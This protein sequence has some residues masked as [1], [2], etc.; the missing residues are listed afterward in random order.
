MRNE[1]LIVGIMVLFALISIGNAGA[2]CGGEY[3]NRFP[4]T[5]PNDYANPV[6]AN[7]TYGVDF[8]DGSQLVWCNATANYL[9]Y[10]DSVNYACYLDDTKMPT[11][12]DEGNETDYGNAEKDLLLYMTLN[13]STDHSRYS[14]S[15]TEN[16]EPTRID[17][18]I[19]HAYSFDNSNDYIKADDSAF[20]RNA[21]KDKFTITAWVY[22]KSVDQDGIVSLQDR[23]A[24]EK[25]ILFVFAG[26]N[27]HCVVHT[28]S[29]FAD[30]YSPNFELNK[31]EMYTC[32][33]D[34]SNVKIYLNNT[35]MDT[36][37]LSGDIDYYS[38]DELWIG[39]R[40]RSPSEYYF[41]GYIDNVMIW[42]R[43]LSADE[44]EAIYNNTHPDG[45]SSL[46][47]SESNIGIF[48]DSPINS[49][50][51]KDPV[52]VTWSNVTD[53]DSV[54]Y[55]FNGGTNTTVTGYFDIYPDIGSNHLEMYMN[56]SGGTIYGDDV[57][58]T[59]TPT[60]TVSIT[61]P[62]N[63]TIVTPPG[64]DINW[65]Y[66]SA[67]ACSYSSYAVDGGSNIS[68]GC[69]NFTLD[70]TSLSTSLHNITVYA[71]N[72]F[73]YS[74]SDTIWI[75]V[76]NP[77]V[78]C[79][80]S[81]AIEAV[82][83]GFF[84][85]SNLINMAA[86]AEYSIDIVAD[87]YS[88]NYN[89]S[90]DNVSNFSICI[91]GNNHVVDMLMTYHAGGYDTRTYYFYHANLNTTLQNIS[92]YLIPSGESEKVEVNVRDS[93]DQDV[94]NA[95]VNIQRYYIDE[96]I[97]RTVAIGKTDASGKFLT[98][99]YPDTVFY[100]YAISLGG[101]TTNVE[102]PSVVVDTANSPESVVLHTVSGGAQFFEIRE[103]VGASCY[104]NYTSN[105]TICIVNDASGLIT[106]ANL[107][108]YHVTL[109]AEEKVCDETG[110]G[111]AFTLSCYLGSDANG[112]YSYKLIITPDPNPPYTLVTGAATYPVLSVFADYGLFP[113]VLL[114]AAMG[115][116]FA[117]N[118]ALG[119]ILSVLGLAVAA[120]FDF[121][122]LTP[123]SIVSLM[124]IA[125]LIFIRRRG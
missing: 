70:L 117:A 118:P 29:T 17:G 87:D 18:H 66:D 77:I 41:N 8:G 125:I 49:T 79:S 19:G 48:I 81:G 38:T 99:L 5:T 95:Y 51:T 43:T 68:T 91:N 64:I 96:N 88:Y 61:N 44:I 60:V 6:L 3:S 26:N 123:V 121:I 115:I 82:R 2:F 4:I 104:V 105:Y 7:D 74:D 120:T 14:K 69:S 32:L 46:G 71:E 90:V 107:I 25:G 93:N 55:S 12:I 114:I 20:Y 101:E 62:A 58:F 109:G 124:G 57:Y 67:R 42:N 53:Y 24:G 16:G 113:T 52:N 36:Q 100:K 89:G 84:N 33:Y 94:P 59:F 34:G 15:F 108:V 45:Y 50:Y 102:G 65:S 27:I 39:A 122:A 119:A 112:S 37:S 40:K 97:Y 83:F 31:W 80:S 78:N 106:S 63:G 103:K 111:S 23:S 30:S 47:A 86:D 35:L 85:E 10:D 73:N 9:C 56:D 22:P 76:R 72:A 92:L 98:Y 116:A 75:D 28:S 11:F 13:D 54:W 110:S 21:I 1:A